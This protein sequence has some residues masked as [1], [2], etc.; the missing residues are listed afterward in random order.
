MMAGSRSCR[1]TGSGRN[2]LDLFYGSDTILIE[3]GLQAPL[4]YLV[5]LISTRLPCPR[6]PAT[7]GGRQLNRHDY[8]AMKMYSSTDR[9]AAA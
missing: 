2:S 7:P 4:M 8:R 6:P 3:V 1:L 5:G 9:R